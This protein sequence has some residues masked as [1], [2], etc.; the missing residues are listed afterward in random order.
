MLPSVLKL[1]RFGVAYGLRV[2][3][4]CVDLDVA[5]RGTTCLMGPV[6][7]GKSTLLRTLAGRNDGEPSLRTWGKAIDR[8]AS[9]RSGLRPALVGQGAKLLKGKVVE[10]VVS[11][12][13]DRAQLQRGEQRCLALAL[14]ESLGMDD[15]A[16]RLDQPASELPRGALRLASLAVAIASDPALLLVDEPTAG[17][18]DEDRRRVLEVI[19]RRAETH[20][21]LLVTHCRTDALALAGRTAL[22]AGGAIIEE[23]ETTELFRAP[24]TPI[25]QA[26]VETG[27]C[28]V[29]S[30]P[31][32][33]QLVAD[34]LVPSSYLELPERREAP[35]TSDWSAFPEPVLAVRWVQD[36][37][38]AGVARPGL[39]SSVDRDLSTLAASGIRL[40]VCLEESQV[41]P[42]DL[43]ARYGIENHGLPIVDM[44]VPSIE[45]AVSL[46]AVIDEAI[47]GGRPVA[48]H[49]RAGL[50]RTGTVLC[51]YLMWKGLA[52]DRALS[53]IRGVE[54]RFVQSE[55]QLEFLTEFEHHLLGRSESRTDP[56]LLHT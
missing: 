8:G 47:D 43:L 2:V 6:G 23:A 34:G 9:L 18:H 52:R 5:L 19:R 37:A 17:L 29:G 48:V 4:A 56:H 11:A 15:L 50:G 38:L 27:S 39:L 21:V 49:C 44:D 51:A 32:L 40:L 7:A 31:T 3:L 16:A 42:D 36:G 54:A 12:L 1:E 46:C 22:L 41:V 30:P 25:A 14:L 55:R 10:A 26:F 24:R 53:R 45:D 28:A 13:P 35:Q 33:D 20:A